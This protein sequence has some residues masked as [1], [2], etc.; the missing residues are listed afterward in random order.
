MHPTE[1]RERNYFKAVY[2]MKKAEFF[3]K[4]QQIRQSLQSMKRWMNLV[5]GLCC[6][7]GWSLKESLLKKSCRL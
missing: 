2:F 4:L 1:I 3:L 5:A 6:R 7:H